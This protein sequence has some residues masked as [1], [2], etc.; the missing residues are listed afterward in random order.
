MLEVRGAD[1]VPPGLT[2]ALPAL[3]KGLL[4]D[5]SALRRRVG[6]ACATGAARGAR[7]RARGRGA[8]RARGALS[9]SE[10]VLELARE[11]VAIARDGL[12]RHRRTPAGAT[13]TRRGFLDPV[14]AQL[15]LGKSPGEV[16]ARALGR[17]LAPLGGSLDRVRAVLIESA[18]SHTPRGAMASRVAFKITFSLDEHDS[19][20]F[21]GLYKDGQAEREGGRCAEDPGRGEAR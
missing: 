4:Y 12:R 14:F 5:A 10:P 19:A 6:A 1:A 18:A 20:Y 16:V 11:L 21:Q 7:G 15:A 2:C 13:P 9:A 17:R 3:W 8:A